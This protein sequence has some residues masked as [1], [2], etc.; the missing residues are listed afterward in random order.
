MASVQ[1][2][3]TGF[4]A[5]VRLKGYPHLSKLFKT[6]REAVDWARQKELELLKGGY[7][8]AIGNLT[9]SDVLSRYEATI[10]VNKRGLGPEAS[11]LKKMRSDSL[12]RYGLEQ[13]T[14]VH[15]AEYRDRRLAQG[16]TG[17]TVVKELNLLSAV[18]EACR[19]DWGLM[20]TNPVR[21]VRKPKTGPA[22]E[23]RLEPGEL[24]AILERS[25]TKTLRLSLILAIETGMR[26]G[27]IASLSWDRVNIEKRVIYLHE[28]KNGRVRHVP[29]SKRALEALKEFGIGREGR[30]FEMAP[31]SLSQAFERV[32]RRAGIKNLRFHDLRHEATSRL[33]EKGLSIMEVATIT[34]H[35]TLAMLQRY[36][37]LRQENILLKLDQ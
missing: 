34:G 25:K 26:R 14:A 18:F 10:T 1:R 27:E 20:V 7:V 28:T 29:L 17:D 23:R 2:R 19:K 31:E 30:V 5:Q 15:I 13:I 35:R 33:F 9:M 24:E 3:K 22:R 32:A 12:C 21:D 6:R 16:V 37:H 8:A 4:Q 36:A 11:R